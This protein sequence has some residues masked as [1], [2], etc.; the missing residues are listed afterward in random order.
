MRERTGKSARL[1]AVD[2]DQDKVN[3][4]PEPEVKAEPKAEKP[5]EQ[6]S[7]E[8]VK[9]EDKT[10]KAEKQAQPEEKVPAEETAKSESKE[11]EGES[12]DQPQGKSEEKK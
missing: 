12:A 4:V 6:A 10:E 8:T 11:A 9:P 2:F 7:E 3:Y 1:S 5:D